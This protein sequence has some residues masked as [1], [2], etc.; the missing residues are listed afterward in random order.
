MEI[1]VLCGFN[2]CESSDPER[3]HLGKPAAGL[4]CLQAYRTL[5][6]A[7]QLIVGLLLGALLAACF[8]VRP[9]WLA[10]LAGLLPSVPRYPMWVL[11]EFPSIA[12]EAEWMMVAVC[13]GAIGGGTYDYIGYV[14]CFREKAWGAI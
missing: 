1:K 5:E 14:G 11:S 2:F 6:R 8:A 10:M 12:E 9:D 7:Q 3:P 13:L 4:N